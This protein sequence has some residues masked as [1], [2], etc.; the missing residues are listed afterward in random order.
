MGE[1]RNGMTSQNSPECEET[2]G[3]ASSL[4]EQQRQ[5]QRERDIARL[6]DEYIAYMAAPTRHWTEFDRHAPRYNSWYR[7]DP[8]NLTLEGCHPDYNPKPN[9]EPERNP[10]HAWFALIAK[11]DTFST[12]DGIRRTIVE[13]STYGINQALLDDGLLDVMYPSEYRYVPKE[14]LNS[15]S[16]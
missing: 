6:E 14:I 7:L 5:R 2:R 3:L 8:T 16:A 13:K 4:E 9:P 1:Q 12:T 10:L 11:G 15:N